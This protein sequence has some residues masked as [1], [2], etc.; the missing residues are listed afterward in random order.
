MTVKQT[1]G[2][3]AANHIRACLHSNY[4]AFQNPKT[5]RWKKKKKKKKKE[6]E[7]MAD[8]IVA[9]AE[10]EFLASDVKSSNDWELFKENVRPLKRGRNVDLLNWALKAQ[11]DSLSKKSLLEHRRKLIEAIDEYK[12]EDPLQPWLE[13]IKWVQESFPS[14]GEYSGL[15]LIYEQC[16][17][18]FWHQERYKND[19]RYLKVWLEYA[20]NCSD[21]EVIYSFLDANEI[22]QNHAIYYVAYALHMESK[23]KMKK[24][25]EIF[26]IGIA[27]KAQPIEKLESSYKKFMGRAIARSKAQDEEVVED[28]LPVR[29]FGTIVAAREARRQTTRQSDIFQNKAKLQRVSSNAPLAVYND[30]ILGTQARHPHSGANQLDA[31]K[32]QGH[33]WK[34]L[35]TQAE[36]NKENSSLPSKWT[37]HKIPQRMGVRSGA[38]SGV[39]L[40]VFIDEEC[41]RPTSKVNDNSL[42]YYAVFKS[43]FVL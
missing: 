18:T 28:H 5:R 42:V 29:S 39:A 16:V 35:G 6:G 8:A 36:R 37:S 1:F 31:T 17:R 3:K 13:C 33:A 2:I 9:D 25:D 27:R 22:G 38:T 15:L 26:N 21:A 30:A 40:E 7:A 20:E 34:T 23:N 19:L 41:A 32:S 43:N 12:G 11:K 24:A 10:A 4:L 14:G